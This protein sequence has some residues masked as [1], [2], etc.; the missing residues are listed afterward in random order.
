MVLGFLC[1][2]FGFSF[3]VR[4]IGYDF[5]W[6]IR[7]IFLEVPTKLII[8]IVL[9]IFSFISFISLSPTSGLG[10]NNGFYYFIL[11]LSS[12]LPSEQPQGYRAL[13]GLG[14]YLYYFVLFTILWY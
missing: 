13:D 4:I 11:R 9:F 7:F 14:F 8:I 2:G 6:P 12:H 5:H 1:I 3:L 10:F